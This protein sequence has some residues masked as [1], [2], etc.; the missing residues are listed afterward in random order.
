M[1]SLSFLHTIHK[2]ASLIIFM[3]ILSLF[4]AIFFLNSD[5]DLLS[6]IVLYL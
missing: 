5:T 4:V 1:N 6:F 3:Y 2:P